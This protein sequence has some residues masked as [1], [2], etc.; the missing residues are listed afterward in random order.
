MAPVASF[1]QKLRLAAWAAPVGYGPA[2][3]VRGRPGGHDRSLAEELERR[4]LTGPLT[5]R[6]LRPFLAGV[7]A[8]EELATSRRLAE[9]LLRSF[10]R[11]RPSLPAAG[12]QAMPDQLASRLPDG[13]VHCGTPVRRV[14]GVVAGPVPRVQVVTDDGVLTA[15]AVVVATDPSAAARLIGWSASAV[16]AMKALTTFWFRTDEA[17][18]RRALLHV[19]GDRRGPLVNTAVVSRAAP[20]YAATGSLVASTVVGARGDLADDVR[21]QTGVVYGVDPSRWELVRTDVVA[22]ALPAFPPGTPLRRAV[23]LGEG[24]FVAGDHRDT[25]SIQGALVSG[26]RAGDAVLASLGTGRLPS[27]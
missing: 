5:D 17:P 19:D 8:E 2:G 13:T 20:G 21:R 9:L 6:V 4:G 7:L 18:T 10:L 22:A 16:P 12:M 14:S 23:G 24:L 3:R 1:A 11:G 25:P 26:R 15:R 27:R